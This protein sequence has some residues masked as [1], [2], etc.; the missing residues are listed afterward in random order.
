MGVFMGVD[1]HTRSRTVCWSEEADGEVLLPNPNDDWQP[2]DMGVLS[3]AGKMR[4]PQQRSD[5]M[6]LLQPVSREEVPTITSL[7]LRN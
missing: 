1:F 2:D 4:R 5:G 7:T 6:M 3:V